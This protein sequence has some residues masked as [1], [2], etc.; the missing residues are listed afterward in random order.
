MALFIGAGIG[1]DNLNNGKLHLLKLNKWQWLKIIL[2]VR[3]ERLKLKKLR[4]N[5]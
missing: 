1:E 2:I 4:Q 3:I 5:G